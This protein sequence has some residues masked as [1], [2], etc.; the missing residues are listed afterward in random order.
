MTSG[1]N[2]A[3]DRQFQLGFQG[4]ATVGNGDFRSL[5]VNYGYTTQGLRVVVAS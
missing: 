2:T 5:G 4:N 1:A 3:T